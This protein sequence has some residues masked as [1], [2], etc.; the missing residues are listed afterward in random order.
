MR[1]HINALMPAFALGGAAATLMGQNIGAGNI[2][3]A[4]K[5]VW[6]ATLMDMGVMFIAGFIFY[7]FSHAIISIFTNDSRVIAV[8]SEFIRISAFFYIFIAFGVVLNRALGGAGDTVVPML[9]TFISL[10]GYLVP[11]AYWVAKYTGFG[12]T[13][14]WWVMATSYAFNGLL[15]LAWFEIGRWKKARVTLYN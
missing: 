6:A 14:I 15:T 4:K 5:S 13:G 7:N 10:W 12:L 9:I 8:G 3:R 2:D 11:A 1:I